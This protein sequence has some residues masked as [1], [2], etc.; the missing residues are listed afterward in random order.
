[1]DIIIRRADENDMD[2]LYDMIREFAKFAGKSNKIS[3]TKTELCNEQ[4][5]YV[6]FLAESIHNEIAGYVLFFPTFHTWTGKGIFVDDLYVREDYR[7]LGI[8]TRLINTA[9]DYGKENGCTKAQWDVDAD[10]KDAIAL[11][12]KLGAV[13]GDNNLNCELFI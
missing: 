11:Y 5:S 1:M 6:C 3:L 4:N 2:E 10:N 12:Q 9:L 8:G 7:R 13:V